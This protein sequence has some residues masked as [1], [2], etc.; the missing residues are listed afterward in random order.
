MVFNEEEFKKRLLATFKIEADEH[1]LSMTEKFIELEQE[2]AT[3]QKKELVEIVYREAH[4]LKGAARAVDLL[5]VETICR[6]LESL[7]SAVKKGE[8]DLNPGMF[9]VLHETLDLIKLVLDNEQKLYN[10]S[11]ILETVSNLNKLKAGEIISRRKKINQTDA[12]KES[13]ISLP[14]PTNTHKQTQRPPLT[15]SNSDEVRFTGNFEKDFEQQLQKEQHPELDQTIKQAHSSADLISETEIIRPQ[16]ISEPNPKAGRRNSE[17]VR[18]GIDKLDYFMMQTEELIPVKQNISQRR[19]DIQS[20][21]ENLLGLKKDWK[22][23]IQFKGN[24]DKS[25]NIHEFKVLQDFVNRK[26]ADINSLASSIDQ[27]ENELEHDQFITDSLIDNLLTDIRKVVMFPFSSLLSGMNK[28][29]R[30]IARDQ[31]K[32]IQFELK[33]EE[34]E[35]DRKILQSLKDP[36]IHLLRNAVDHGIENV[37]TRLRN[38]KEAKA[39]ISIRISQISSNKVNIQIV[40]DGAGINPEDVKLKALKNGVI[41]QKEANTM[42]EAQ[43]IDL[44]FHSGLTTAKIITDIYGRGLGLAIVKDSIESLGGTINIHTEINK[45][46]TFNIEI[47][48]TL[49]TFRGVF[50]KAS[51]RTYALPTA[52]LKRVVRIKSDDLQTI[53][54]KQSFAFE[55]E[56][57]PFVRLEH[58]LDEKCMGSKG[59]TKHIPVLVL[60]HGNS[61]FGFGIDEVLYEQEVLVKPFD[62]MLERVRNIAGVTVVGSGEIVP[63]LYVPDIIRSTVNNKSSYIPND[64]IEVQ[65]KKS[66]LIAEDSITARTLLKDILEASDYSVTAAVDGAEAYRYLQQSVFDCVISDIEM[67]NMTGIELTQEI[68]KQD[69]YSGLPIILVTALRTQ[70]D[71]E[72]GLEA[73]ANAYIEKGGFNPQYLLDII[74]RLIG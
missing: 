32:D 4:S 69:K 42:N 13:V 16:N 48:I 52:Y 46:T 3:D 51:D 60:S 49:T 38:N 7:F 25:I 31:S 11:L 58:I 9:D 63:L 18:I 24:H 59:N 64:V 20:I 27:F 26:Y 61:I 67:P 12:P 55:G 39:I 53:E 22:K 17:T 50:V 44:I 34:T 33:G 54:G 41:S 66:I 70:Q 10:P 37:A 6:G 30:D 19:I 72:R 36:I 71:R 56:M 40:D 73:G 2:P 57:I 5:D 1:I 28:M 68:R 21:R 35:I 65:N 8:L 14:E 43:I 47:P 15:K 74:K 62:K 23:V 29:V 45:G